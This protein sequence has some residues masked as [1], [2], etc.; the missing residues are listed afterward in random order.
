MIFPF[1]VTPRLAAIAASGAIHARVFA[2]LAFTA[3]GTGRAAGAPETHE[4]AP[5]PLLIAPSIEPVSNEAREAD[6]RPTP[7]STSDDHNLRPRPAARAATPRVAPEKPAPLPARPAV[8]P[9][10]LERFMTT[11]LP[12]SAAPVPLATDE[13]GLATPSDRAGTPA[14][15]APEITFGEDDVSIPARLLSHVNATYPIA[16]WSS[17][18]E[19]DV[20]VEIVVDARGSVVSTRVVTRRGHGFDE[21]A[22]ASL[23]SYRFTPA[24]RDGHAV[25]VRVR[26]SIQFRRRQ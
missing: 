14:G 13:G 2:S 17:G 11:E 19:A 5:S 21:A 12:P 9:D 20:P 16:A 24:Q 25:R 26:W 3:I 8:A 1:S 6:H 15:P 18:V 22:L 10:L 4:D 23:Q 7:P